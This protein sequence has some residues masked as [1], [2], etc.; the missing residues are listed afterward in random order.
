MGRVRSTLY[1]DLVGENAPALRR[2]AVATPIGLVTALVFGLEGPWQLGL[3]AGWIA[4]ALV[5]LGTVTPILLRSDA[6]R[7][8]QLAV[9]EDVNREVARLLLLVASSASLVAVGFAL[10]EAQKETGAETVFL[11]G[12]ATVTVFVSWTVVNVLFALRYAHLYYV[13]PAA[14]IDFDVTE[15]GPPDYRDFAYMAF[16][17]GM[18]YQVSDTTLRARGIR[19]NVLVHALISYVFGV[20]I[21]AGG[22]NTIAGLL[23]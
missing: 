19:R 18:T 2:V 8:K 17:I 7:T 22:V 15:A 4:T 16:T 10:E 11:V 14:E 12:L 5:F 9:R 23:S 3:L 13:P 6:V 20:V 21:V 1:H